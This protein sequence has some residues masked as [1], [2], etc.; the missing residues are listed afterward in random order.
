M[1]KVI[2]S[3]IMI[4]STTNLYA[5]DPFDVTGNNPDLYEGFSDSHVFPTVAQSGYGEN[6]ASSAL[7]KSGFTKNCKVANLGSD[8]AYGSV[9]LDIGHPINW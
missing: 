1:K 2:I 9:L 3:I 8:D 4:L 5:H 6:Y 7:Y